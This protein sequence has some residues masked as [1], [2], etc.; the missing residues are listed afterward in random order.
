MA[1]T[2]EWDRPLDARTKRHAVDYATRSA[3]FA[4]QRGEASIATRIARQLCLA[5]PK[6]REH[7]HLLERALATRDAAS[8]LIARESTSADPET[9]NAVAA[10]HLALGDLTTAANLWLSLAREDSTRLDAFV[11]FAWCMARAGNSASAGQIANHVAGLASHPKIEAVLMMVALADGDHARALDHART[12]LAEDANAQVWLPMGA[13]FASTGVVSESA[14]LLGLKLEN[15]SGTMHLYEIASAMREGRNQAAVAA[16]DEVLGIVPD[17]HWAAMF[18]IIALLNDGDKVGAVQAQTALATATGSRLDT[19]M[20]LLDLLYEVE[21]FQEVVD[22]GMAVLEQLPAH[23][24]L[25]FGIAHSAA[26]IGDLDTVE[27]ILA[28]LPA[29]LSDAQKAHLSPFMVLTFFDDPALQKQTAM[30]RSLGFPTPAEACPVPLPGVPR[31]GRIRIGYLSN[32]YH[33]HATLKLLTEVLEATDRDRFETIAYSY[34][35]KP[36]DADRARM[37]AAVDRFVDVQDMAD[38]EIAEQARR[39]G[40]HVMVDLKGYT[41]GS[42]LGMLKHR[43]APIQVNWLGYPGTYG[44]SEVDYVIADGFIVPPAADEYYTEKVVRLPDSYQPNSRTRQVA[45]IPTRQQ[46]GLP[47]EGFVFASFNQAYKIN[48]ELFATW[49]DILAGVPGST[50]WLLAKNEAISARLRERAMRYGID[51]ERLVFA[52]PFSHAFHLARYGLVDLALDTFPVGSHTTASDA[53]WMGAPLLALTGRSFVSRV[54][55]SV[56]EAAGMS[57]LIA[58]S[59]DEYRAKA[60]TLGNDPGSARA[61]RE[62]LI[63]TRG[64]MPLFDPARFAA[65]LGAAYQTMVDIWRRGEAPRSFDVAP[66][67]TAVPP[68]QILAG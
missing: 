32:D 43:L 33:N 12:A 17:D 34:D 2:L 14:F 29:R 50:L 21:S 45:D 18:K 11:S 31:S 23:H 53:L 41:G 27:R 28:S 42:R 38:H 9:I 5:Q 4:L 24:G 19:L 8:D 30:R 36:G 66:L 47:A 1:T 44:M 59:M 52:P 3:E 62:T 37:A 61:L 7:Q 39:D 58:R 65:H 48:S 22:L 35:R 51:G 20:R 6:V 63:R 13:V 49:M 60:I 56:L 68:A 15:L 67:R 26:H 16:A 64:S 40:V 25:P 54:S 46:A 10:A 57:H 55:G